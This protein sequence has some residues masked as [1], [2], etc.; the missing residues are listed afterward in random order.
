MWLSWTECIYMIA[1]YMIY[2]TWSLND[3]Y[4]NIILYVWTIQFK[5]TLALAKANI[6][7]K[8][9]G[10][11][12]KNLTF[13]F[14]ILSLTMHVFLFMNLI[15]SL[16]SVWKRINP[17][18]GIRI[19]FHSG[20]VE[21]TMKWMRNWENQYLTAVLYMNDGEMVGKMEAVT[22]IINIFILTSIPYVLHRWNSLCDCL[23]LIH[24]LFMQLI[25]MQ[26]FIWAI[27]SVNLFQRWPIFTGYHQ[28]LFNALVLV[29][30][31][32]VWHWCN[33]VVDVDTKFYLL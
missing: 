6:I 28:L 21:C 26:R 31:Y 9:T 30:F 23:F 10:K 16:I 17:I 25:F 24:G 5:C 18:Q 22:D 12:L 19:L 15:V 20:C 13:Q 1:C 4:Y 27:V 7:V 29:F 14:F 8:K 11:L 32:T 33:Y 3:S 2:R